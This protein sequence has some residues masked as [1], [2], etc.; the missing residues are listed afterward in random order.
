MIENPRSPS[1]IQHEGHDEPGEQV[2]PRIGEP[3]GT[4]PRHRRA[5]GGSWGRRGQVRCFQVGGLKGQVVGGR[6]AGPT[7]PRGGHAP[8][9]VGPAGS[10]TLPIVRK[11][12]SPRGAV[13]STVLGT[14]FLRTADLDPVPAPV[15]RHGVRVVAVLFL[16][17]AT[18][19]DHARRRLANPYGRGVHQHHLHRRVDDRRRPDRGAA[20]RWLPA[21]AFAPAWRRPEDRGQAAAGTTVGRGPSSSS[22]VRHAASSA[23][24]SCWSGWKSGRR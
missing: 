17:C 14:G 8:G 2:R 7:R 15:G 4:Q 6:V 18:L 1:G 20:R 24:V 3:G 9:P 16:K 12:C 22:Q 10:A 11:S 5:E 23:V 19:H 13:P 21:S